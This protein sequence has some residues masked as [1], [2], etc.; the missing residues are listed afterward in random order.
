M[1]FIVFDYELIG[2][3]KLPFTEMGE[4]AGTVWN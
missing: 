3:I 2:G 1:D 4:T